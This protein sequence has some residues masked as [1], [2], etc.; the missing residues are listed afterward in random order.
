MATSSSS[1][2]ATPTAAPATRL[3]RLSRDA[4]RASRSSSLL[5]AMAAEARGSPRAPEAVAGLGPGSGPP[6]RLRPGPP[7]PAGSRLSGAVPQTFRQGGG[8]RGELGQ[9]A[10]DGSNPWSSITLL[11]SLTFPGAWDPRLRGRRASHGPRM[12]ALRAAALSRM[13]ALGPRLP[14]RIAPGRP[15]RGTT[16]RSGR[17]GLGAAGGAH[18]T[19]PPGR[20]ALRLG[21]RR[22]LTH[23]STPAAA[24][25]P[26]GAPAP[27]LSP[28]SALPLCVPNLPP[29][30][31]RAA[32]R[33]V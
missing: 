1:T 15:A 14:R 7:A 10:P 30:P 29:L 31:P 27:R 3:R 6:R 33:V 2:M 12:P 23:L 20:F 32:V 22:A 16:Q 8:S 28:A 24:P 9:G 21:S 19:R 18:R 13:A 17:P 5:G 11:F 26:A 25:A 4:A